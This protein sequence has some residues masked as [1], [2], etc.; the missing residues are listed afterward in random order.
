MILFLS[1]IIAAGAC[2]NE[3]KSTKM[4]NPLLSEFSTPYGVPPFDQISLDD[5]IPAFEKAI[6]IHKQE[7]DEIVQN[8]GE[9]TFENTIVALEN[10]GSK[11]EQVEGV[12]Y[13]LNSSLTGPEMQEIATRL[14]PITSAHRDAIRMNEDL[15]L[16]VKAVYAKKDEL[17]LKGEDAKLL[18]ETYKYF[19]RGG[20]NLN[21]EDKEKLKKIN[22]ELSMASLKFGQNVLKETN[23]FKLVIEDEKDLS[24]LTEGVISGAAETAKEAGEEGKWVFTVQKPSMIPFLTYADNRELRKKLHTAYTML[25]NNDNEF[26][27]KEIIKKIVKL[28]ADRARLLGYTNHAEYILEENMAKNEKTVADFLWKVWEPGLKKA[29]Q[30]SAELQAMIR[31]EGNDFELEPWDWWYYSEKLR[32][33]KFDLDE[34]MISQYFVVDNV[35]DGAFKLASNLYGLQFEKLTDVPVYHPDVQ[36]FKVTDSKGDLVGILYMDFFPR[37]SKRAGAWMSEYRGQKVVDGKDI[38][39]VVTTNFNF[40]KP[41]ADKP[42]LLT[43][44]EVSTTFHE[45]GHALHGLLSECHYG[46]L[47]GT[48]VSRDFVELPSQIM[49]NW[50]F[51]PEVL[52][53]YATH[54]KSGEVIPEELIKKLQDSRFFNQGF[55][56]TEYMSATFLDMAYHVLDVEHADIEDINEFETKAMDK[57]GLIDDIV[58]RYRSPYF[59]HIFAGGYSMGYYAYIWAEVL[60]SDAFM[61]FKETGD[62]YN[63]EVAGAFRSNVLSKGGT[64]DAMDLYMAFRGKEPGPEALL[65]KRG[66]LN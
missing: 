37:A 60:D 51:E 45:F 36:A 24:G 17:Q 38:R 4:E 55:I 50:A 54:Y 31:A 32:K 49:E 39:P 22:E 56:T 15:F 6:E 65:A 48:N 52:K 3:E 8:D 7:I 25:G 30:E 18:E 42:A 20:A 44:D 53:T 46:S 13:N 28:R 47:A 12:F 29:K 11:L 16:K 19:V 33:E 61:A 1:V 59:S 35:R 26:D 34:E 57:I 14:S 64:V 41:T 23:N 58:V 62:L 63:Q 9:A 21:S 27:N 2:K 43:A 66:L 10:A 40:T 5:F